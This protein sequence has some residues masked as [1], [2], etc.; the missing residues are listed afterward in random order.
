MNV[1]KQTHH[2]SVMM[3]VIEVVGKYRELGLSLISKQDA[4]LPTTNHQPPEV[5][6]VFLR[7]LCY[8]L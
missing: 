7:G 6:T 2:L 4:T 8:S 3:K 5:T 1:A